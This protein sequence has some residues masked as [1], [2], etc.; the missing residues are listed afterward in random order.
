VIKESAQLTLV[1]LALRAYAVYLVT[2][3]ALYRM[4]SILHGYSLL[5]ADAR[6]RRQTY[7]QALGSDRVS[8]L[9]RPL[10]RRTLYFWLWFVLTS[11]IYIGV[12]A[13]LWLAASNLTG[14]LTTLGV[15]PAAPTPSP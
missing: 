13:G 5:R 6:Q 14:L 11:L 2:F 12:A 7:V 15:P 8:V 4:F 1:A 10:H 3:P 9:F